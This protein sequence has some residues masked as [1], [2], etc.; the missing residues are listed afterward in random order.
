MTA[1]TCQA[2]TDS[3]ND[4][5]R[6]LPVEE[7]FE[8]WMVFHGRSYADESEKEKR[9]NIFKKN[10]EYV[11]SFNNAGNHTFTLGINAFSDMTDEEFADIY[12]RRNCSRTAS[13]HRPRRPSGNKPL[14]EP[15]NG[16][17]HNV[18]LSALPVAVD[19]VRLGAVT[20]VKNQG[21]CGCCWAFATVAAVEGLNKIH[22]GS[23]VDL[24][25]QQLIDCEPYSEGCGGGSMDDAYDYVVENDRLAKEK[26]YP[27]VGQ[28]RT[29]RDDKVESVA[30][31]KGYASVPSLHN[32]AAL[33]AAVAGQPVSAS[34]AFGDDYVPRFK[35][36]RGGVYSPDPRGYCG[37]PKGNFHDI[38]IVG[39]LPSYWIIKNSW[40][41]G[42]GEGGYMRL[43]RQANVV[44]PC[45]I[46]R[47][48]VH[49]IPYPIDAKPSPPMAS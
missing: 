40:G 20:S 38:A 18:S 4:T 27:Y 48:A 10:K 1:L 35:N 47:E 9:F 19:W 34:I 43:A 36:Y 16:P 24:S 28:K 21:S 32:E 15:H 7:H 14:I 8:K 5:F 11:E 45:G 37:D 44:G 33:L 17:F 41:T 30:S 49:P 23:L 3:Q 13:E 6:E 31:I 46:F 26:D 39:Y 42:W 2:A 25:E 12:L 29:C 22:Y